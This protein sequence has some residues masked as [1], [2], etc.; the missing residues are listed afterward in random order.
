MSLIKVVR[1]VSLE[2]IDQQGSALCPPPLVT[3][4]VLYLHFFE[5]SAIVQLNK[6]C[7]PNRALRWI[8]IL[9]GKAWLF[10]TVN[11]GTKLVDT[12]VRSGFI[13][14]TLG[15]EFTMNERVRNHVADGVT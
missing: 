3:N 9:D 1:N 6:E 13:G 15:S 12:R 14:I 11:F 10:N 2:F 8:V 4:R 5:L 7:I